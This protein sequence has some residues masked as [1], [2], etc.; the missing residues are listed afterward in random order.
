[1]LAPALVGLTD[2]EVTVGEAVSAAAKLLGEGAY[3]YIGDDGLA[4]FDGFAA[5]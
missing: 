3:G 5:V 1:M 2:A 4:H